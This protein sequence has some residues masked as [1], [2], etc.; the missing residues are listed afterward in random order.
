MK[1]ARKFVLSAILAVF[2]VGLATLP[3]PAAAGQKSVKSGQPMNPIGDVA[4]NEIFPIKIAGFQVVPGGNYDNADSW[5]IPLCICP[6]PYPRY[7]RIGVPLSF[8][9]ASRLIETVSTPYYF[10][11]IGK[12]MGNNKGYL[13]GANSNLSAGVIPAQDTN[14]QAH[15]W[16]FLVWSLISDEVE[17][18]CLESDN[19]FD[20]AYMTEIDPLW[21]EDDVAFIIQPEALLFANKFAQMA[22]MADS[23]SVNDYAPLEPLFWCVGSGGSSY[24]LTG[25]VNDSKIIQANFTIATRMI[26]KLAREFLICD[27]NVFVCGCSMTPIWRKSNYKLQPVRP[28]VEKIAWPVGKSQYFYG[29][30]LNPP[31]KGQKGPS[32][33]FMW[34]LFRKHTCC[35]SET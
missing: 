27:P 12:S 15:F 24:P 34:L 30:G 10:P 20:L 2:M 1:Y 22:C 7:Y 3:A 4:W 11:I 23:I 9:E 5:R 29:S 6:A 18:L 33:E 25:H 8:W 35:A 21:Q 17:D 32:G 26:Y 16:Y 14:A 13:Q 31:I 28:M 19:S